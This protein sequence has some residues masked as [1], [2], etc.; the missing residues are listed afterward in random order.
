[1][2]TDFEMN[3]PVKSLFTTQTAV[4]IL[5]CRSKEWLYNLLWKY[6]DQLSEPKYI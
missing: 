3:L 4:L 2:E 1:M 5:P 6:N